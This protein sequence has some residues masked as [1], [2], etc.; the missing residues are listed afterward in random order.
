M[1]HSKVWRSVGAVLVLLGTAQLSQAQSPTPAE[2]AIQYRQAVFKVIAGNF[3]PLAQNAQG[4]LELPPGAARK[5]AE[6][7]AAIS[8]F[9]ADAFPDISREGETKAKPEIWT[10]RAEFDKLLADLTTATRSLA[11]VTANGSA[12]PEDFKAAVGAVGNAC[13]A[14][15]DKYRAK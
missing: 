2:K 1:I 6:R 12:K 15:H 8:E 11:T 10:S 5:Y 13:K 14:C 9:A 3:G 4:K 7:L